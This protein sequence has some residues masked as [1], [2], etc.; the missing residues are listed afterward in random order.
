MKKI[1]ISAYPFMCGMEDK[2]FE[3]RTACEKLP[4][5]L[6]INELKEYNP[7]GIIAGLET[8]DKSI[9]KVC[10][11]LKVISRIGSG[12]DNINLKDAKDFGITV[13][14]TPSEP[15]QAVAEL[16]IAQMINLLRHIPKYPQYINTPKPI[17]EKN[18][19]WSNKILGKNLKDCTVGIIGFG[20]IGR[21]VYDILDAFGAKL[22]IYDI[23]QYMDGEHWLADLIELLKNSDIVTLHIPLN[24][25]NYHFFNRDKL[26]YMKKG[27]YLINTSRG[28]VVSEGDL[29]NVLNSGHLAGAAL[30]VFEHEP[31][32]GV[33]RFLPNVISTPHIGSYTEG[34]RKAMELKAFENI[35]DYLINT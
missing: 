34:A 22:M 26:K 35:V 29:Y 23:N 25:D 6:L 12:I 32:T 11:N 30:D 27:S 33:L 16:V 9:F 2:T 28:A 3:F 21:K 5:D 7:D 18:Q 15:V 19:L 8:Y 14:N 1:Y 20:N 10:P 17:P 24:D 31:Y 13:L 4:P